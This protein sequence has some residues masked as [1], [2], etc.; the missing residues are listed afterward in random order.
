MIPSNVSINTSTEDTDT[1]Y[2]TEL[3]L[4]S[5][6]LL[7]KFTAEETQRIAKIMNQEF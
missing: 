3:K 7:G 1:S 6:K 2:A 5:R 4:L